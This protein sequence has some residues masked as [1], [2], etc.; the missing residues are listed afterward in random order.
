[1]MEILDPNIKKIG[2]ETLFLHTGENI[3]RMGE[4]TFIRLNDNSILFAYISFVGRNWCDECTAD[5]AAV[6]SK[7][8][9]ETWSEPRILLKHDENSRN[10]MCPS[11]LRLKNGNIGMVLLRKAGDDCIPHF[12]VSLDEGKT[13]STPKPCFEHGGYYVFENDHAIRLKSGRILAPLNRHEVVNGVIG[14]YAKMVMMASD[15]D[16][17]TWNIISQEISSPFPPEVTATGFQETAIYQM[18]DGRIRGISRTDLGCQW[19]CYSNDEGATW[20]SPVPNRFFT[21]P[22]APL[23]IKDAGDFTIAVFCPMPRFTTRHE[24]RSWGRTPIIAAVSDD[25]GQTFNRVFYL[26]NDLSNGYAYPAIF[27][28]G[29]YMLISYYHSDNL[30]VVLRAT[31]ILKIKYDEIK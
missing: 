14:K 24:V 20:S 17:E 13:F 10:L 30:D 11:L 5:I 23:L 25:K 22:D 26:E 6:V 2:K 28:G 19:E 1:M 3:P 4:G 18:P 12:S 7:D 27:D 16:G 31:K 9:G 21:S 8:E 15:D 29:D